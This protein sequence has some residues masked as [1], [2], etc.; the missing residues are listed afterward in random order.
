MADK[1]CIF[2]KIAQ[3]KIPSKI[4]YE[5]D[6]LIAFRDIDPK[7]PVHILLIPKKHIPSI[8]EL[9]GSD[10]KI[11]GKIPRIFQKIA[12]SESV[13]QSGFR[14]VLNTGPD[15]GQAVAHL[16]FHIF[17]GRKLSWPPG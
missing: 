10:E 3:H 15:A 6:E 12:E 2:C 1:D 17:G 8:T 4:V 5:D 13:A 11:I 16:H 9:T 14:I 7:A